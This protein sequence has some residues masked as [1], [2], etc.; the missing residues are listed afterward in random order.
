MDSWEERPYGWKK[1]TGPKSQI[2]RLRSGHHTGMAATL[3]TLGPYGLKMNDAK[4]EHVEHLGASDGSQ[5]DDFSLKYVFLPFFHESELPRELNFRKGG[6]FY[7][8]LQD[9]KRTG[10]YHNLCNVSNYDIDLKVD[11]E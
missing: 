4:W 1:M 9:E 6:K 3:D 8:V 5:N 11:W 2:L 7:C 10:F